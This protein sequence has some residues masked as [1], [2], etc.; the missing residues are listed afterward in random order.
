MCRDKKTY[1][2]SNNAISKRSGMDSCG[3]YARNHAHTHTVF[4]YMQSLYYIVVFS[5]FFVLLQLAYSYNFFYAEQMQL[6][7]FSSSYA[8]DTLMQPGGLALYL[9]RFIVQLWYIPY[10]GALCVAL[11]LTLTVF[12]TRK[13]LDKITDTTLN[14]ILSVIPSCLLILLHTD[15]SYSVQGT[16]ALILM[17]C[18]LLLSFRFVSNNVFQSLIG[19][20]GFALLFFTTGSVAMLFAVLYLLIVFLK[21]KNFITTLITTVL[22]AMAA[23]MAGYLSLKLAWQGDLRLVLSPDAYYDPLLNNKLLLWSWLSFPAVMLAAFLFKVLKPFKKNIIH[24]LTALQVVLFILFLVHTKVKDRKLFPLMAYQDYLLRNYQWDEIIETFPD[25]HNNQMMNVLCLALAQKGLLGDRLF[26][27]AP[28]GAPSVLETWDNTQQNAMTLSD[29]YFH[30]GDIGTA[31]KF[32]ME[33]MTSSLQNGNTRLLQRLVETNLIFGEYEVAEKYIRMME[34]TLFYRKKGHEYR[35]LL[36]N[37]RAVE[38]D[39]LLGVKR[40]AL[41]S[42]K[43]IAVFNTVRETFEQLAFNNPSCTL[44]MQY[45]LA[46]TLAG[47]DLKTFRSLIEKYFRTPLLPTLSN[48]QQEAVIALEQNNPVFWIK[49]GV[50]TKTEQRFRA[51]DRDMNNQNVKDFVD[52]MQSAHGDTYWFYLV[53]YKNKAT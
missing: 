18:M 7:L 6:F 23:F 19:L 21:S 44:P 53:F 11:L 3:L 42:D 30:I 22:S 16:V 15:I 51:F 45:L 47:K 13:I 40:K 50:T 10:A 28:Q 37:D 5:G 35:A 26:A 25:K 39:F 29:I 14:F 8:W 43:G 32:A 46:L 48:N 33:G 27:Y 36:R 31:Q 17:L 24:I 38:R 12:L 4:P 20:V 2:L 9:A 49:N 41:F 1:T 52:K 34:G